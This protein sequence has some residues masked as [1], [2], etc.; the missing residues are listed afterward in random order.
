MCVVFNL[1]KYT[2]DSFLWGT[3]LNDAVAY[4]SGLAG[5]FPTYR[6]DGSNNPNTVQR[7]GVPFLS[8]I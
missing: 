2:G 5:K 3:L 4:A 7:R 6:A 1:S 8:E